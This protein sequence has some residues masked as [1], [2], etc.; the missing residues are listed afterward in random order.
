MSSMVEKASMR[1]RSRCASASN[2]PANMEARATASHS[3]LAPPK[4]HGALTRNWAS[5]PKAP[6]STT[7]ITAAAVIGD[8]VPGYLRQPEV[9]RHQRQLEREARDDQPHDEPGQRGR[10][11]VRTRAPPPVLPSRPPR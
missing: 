4:T 6:M 1:R 8:V 2:A 10:G 7:E 11:R 3:R 5:S 9:A